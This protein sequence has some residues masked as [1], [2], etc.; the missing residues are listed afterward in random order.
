MGFLLAGF[1]LG[2]AIMFTTENLAWLLLVALFAAIGV[3]DDSKHKFMSKATPWPLR[4]LPIAAISL[5][6]ALAFTQ[7][8]FLVLAGGAFIAALA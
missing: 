1:S 2:S 3:L 5:G 4:A 8:L 7:D 6:F